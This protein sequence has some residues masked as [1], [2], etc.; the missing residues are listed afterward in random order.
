MIVTLCLKNSYIIGIMLY[1]YLNTYL[2]T[3]HSK[4]FNDAICLGIFKGSK[5]QRQ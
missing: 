1:F 2:I 3:V 5:S 4:V